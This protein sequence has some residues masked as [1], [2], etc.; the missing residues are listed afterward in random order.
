M[1][2]AI[3][4]PWAVM[5]AMPNAD[6][7][8]VVLGFATAL[9]LSIPM[10]LRNLQLFGN[11]IPL[12][13]GGSPFV[14]SDWIQSTLKSSIGIF[15]SNSIYLSNFFYAPYLLLSVA[16]TA[17]GVFA[18]RSD[19]KRRAIAMG[20]SALGAV[21]IY[22]LF[23]LRSMDA[24]ASHLLVAAGAWGIF[25]AAGW[26]KILPNDRY[27][28]LIAAVLLLAFLGLNAYVLHLLPERFAAVASRGAY[29]S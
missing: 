23:N 3:L 28:H 1:A 10:A 20:A 12:G 14:A 6:R 26:R 16:A 7:K 24:Q 29:L 18:F 8:N 13:S 9:V 25:C 4:F 21:V 27:F 22:T 15:G 11:V 5:L 2:I 17:V 19:M